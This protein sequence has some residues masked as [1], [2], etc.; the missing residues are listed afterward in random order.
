M[1]T[2]Q[3]TKSRKRQNVAQRAQLSDEQPAGLAQALAQL[4]RYQRELHKNSTPERRL[5]LETLYRLDIP[6]DTDKLYALIK[7]AHPEMP[8]CRATVHNCL[9]L[10]VEARVARRVALTDSAEVYFEK[11][12][13]TTPHGYCICTRCVQIRVLQLNPMDESVRSQ[14]AKSFLIESV[15]YCVQGLCNKCQIE[16]RREMRLQKAALAEAQKQL[17]QKRE[18]AAKRKARAKA[19]Q[20]KLKKGK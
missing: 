1:M 12:F 10:F 8:L 4:E 16:E 19:K 11:S 6:V 17:Q 5:T 18:A 3:E 13:G 7:E 2:R 9:Q 14:I 15:A 20:D